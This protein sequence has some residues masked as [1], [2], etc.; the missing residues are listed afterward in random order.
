MIGEA[1]L[2]FIPLCFSDVYNYIDFI[3]SLWTYILTKVPSSSFI[4][5]KEEPG[6]FR[7]NSST[8]HFPNE[9]GPYKSKE[10][11]M[12]WGFNQRPNFKAQN[13]ARI[14]PSDEIP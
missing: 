3:R 12:Y 2:T 10:P 13:V 11:E 5:D 4:S 7:E 6:V 8:Q 14:T 9:K 1:F